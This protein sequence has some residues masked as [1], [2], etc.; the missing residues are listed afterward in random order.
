MLSIQACPTTVDIY[1]GSG[2]GELSQD[3]VVTELVLDKNIPKMCTG[4][5][6]GKNNPTAGVFYDRT[7][8]CYSFVDRNLANNCQE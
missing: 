1:L 8:I 2:F 7:T 6:L 3:E 5:I 4:L